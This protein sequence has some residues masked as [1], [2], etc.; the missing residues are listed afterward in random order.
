MSIL[1]FDEVA[2]VLEAVGMAETKSESSLTLKF[3]P[4]LESGSSFSTDI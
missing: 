2:P 4:R 3:R 1:D